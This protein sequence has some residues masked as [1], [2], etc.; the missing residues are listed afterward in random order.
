MAMHAG[1][2]DDESRLR[3]SW[4]EQNCY[5]HGMSKHTASYSL[6]RC[7][8]PSNTAHVQNEDVIFNSVLILWGFSDGQ[9]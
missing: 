2:S 4:C 6:N 9:V 8:P 1:R 7:I 3:G 5:N